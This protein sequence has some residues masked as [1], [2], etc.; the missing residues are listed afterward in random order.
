LEELDPADHRAAF[1]L[2]LHDPNP[3]VARRAGKLAKGKGFAV[4]RR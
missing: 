1:L 2:A 4:W 3:D